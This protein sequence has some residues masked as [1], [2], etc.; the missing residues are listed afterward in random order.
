MKKKKALLVKVVNSLGEDIELKLASSFEQYI[1]KEPVEER[2]V[3]FSSLLPKALGREG[4]LLG[5]TDS[6]MIRL[7]KRSVFERKTKL[8]STFLNL[9][10]W[11][12]VSINGHE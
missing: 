12:L 5:T 4:Q 7:G 3:I 8:T 2:N 11:G 9:R 10:G 1:G 6:N